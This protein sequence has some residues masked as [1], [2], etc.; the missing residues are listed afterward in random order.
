MLRF[1]ETTKVLRA[2]SNHTSQSRA[3]VCGLRQEAFSL[4]FAVSE[5]RPQYENI[6]Y[7]TH[8][9][10]IMLRLTSPALTYNAKL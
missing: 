3:I 10:G 9:P 2:D 1:F 7:I 6:P 5:I 4:L 8:V